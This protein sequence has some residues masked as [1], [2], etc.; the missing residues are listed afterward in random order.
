MSKSISFG[1]FPE[2]SLRRG[3]DG[4][5]VFF[6]WGKKCGGYILTESQLAVF[7]HF[8]NKAFFWCLGI[9]VTIPLFV[10]NVV[11]AIIVAVIVLSVYLVF[12]RRKIQEYPPSKD[13]YAELKPYS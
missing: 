8:Q 12:Y 4:A 1:L 3:H 5:I 11:V 7:I 13:A 9:G 2:K 10:K 6:P